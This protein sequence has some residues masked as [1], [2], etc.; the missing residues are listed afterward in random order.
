MLCLIPNFGELLMGNFGYFLTMRHCIQLKSF[1]MEDKDPFYSTK[2]ISWLLMTWRCKDICNHGA[3]LESTWN[4][5]LNT[6]SPPPS[7]TYLLQWIGSALVQ[8]M[9]CHLFS[10][11]PLSEPVLGYWQLDPSEQTS[12]HQTQNFSFMRMHLK[13]LS[14]KS[15]PFC[16]DGDELNQE[17]GIFYFQQQ[18]SKIIQDHTGTCNTLTWW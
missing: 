18:Q 15:Q 2:T 5:R 16:P 3:N 12:V 1:F 7:A 11:Q 17:S 10:A 8:I 4:H 9:A 13:I 14:A 6:H